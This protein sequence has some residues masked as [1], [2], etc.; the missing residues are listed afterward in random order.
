MNTTGTYTLT[1]TVSDAAGN[2]A[3]ITR[4]V[5]V[6]IPANYAT[7][8]NSTVSLEMIWVESGTFT[9]GQNDITNASPEHN[10]TFTQGFYLSK[11]EVTQ[12]QHEAV[13]SG[14][15]GDQNST[16]SNWHG[17]PNQS[18]ENVSW[19]DVQVFL[20]RLNEQQAGNIP[21]G[22][23][24][25]CPRKPSGSMPA[26][27]AQ[28]RGTLWGDTITSTMR[29]ILVVDIPKLVMWDYTM[30]TPGAFLICMAMYANGRTGMGYD[31]S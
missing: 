11:Y 30:P 2:N 6:G 27:Q 13:M 29:I 18:G 15:T 10:I 25:V 9:I 16:P 24:Y 5:H 20:T 17:N 1:Y 3:S 4:T 21:E 19:E 28:T 26:V 8:L 22:W 31:R 23:A 12:A 14:I 7:D